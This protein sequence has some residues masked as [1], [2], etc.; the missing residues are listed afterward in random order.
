MDW[1]L[2][3]F[4]LNCA[5]FLGFLVAFCVLKFNDFKHLEKAVEEL[6]NTHEKFREEEHQKHS[7]N[8]EVLRELTGQ[9]AYLNGKANATEEINKKK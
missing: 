3:S 2:A 1:K 7:Q 8:L 6:K 9:V 4:V 5:Q